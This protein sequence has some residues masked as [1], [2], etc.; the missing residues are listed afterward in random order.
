MAPKPVAGEVSTNLSH[1]V[2]ELL[3][4]ARL[5]FQTALDAGKLHASGLP[6]RCR[7]PGSC[8]E[9]MLRTAAVSDGRE[10]VHQTISQLF[11]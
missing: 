2:A 5:R 11:V 3:S 1:R 7:G 10:F 8:S 6:P 4:E 9:P